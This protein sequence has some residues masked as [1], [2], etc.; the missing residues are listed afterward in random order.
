MDFQGLNNV[1]EFSIRYV[2]FSLL[3]TKKLKESSALG[4]TFLKTKYHTNYSTYPYK[5]DWVFFK[6]EYA[7]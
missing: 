7:E 3:K 5:K 6:F 2:L 4:G 1:F